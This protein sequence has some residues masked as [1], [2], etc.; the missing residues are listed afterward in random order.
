MLATSR[1]IADIG[2]A[3]MRLGL[4]EEFGG[5]IACYFQMPSGHAKSAADN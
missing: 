5:A 1:L 2:G 4:C 3:S